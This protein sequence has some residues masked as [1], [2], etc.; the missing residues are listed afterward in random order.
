M[1]VFPVNIPPAPYAL[2]AIF[3]TILYTTV[4]LPKGNGSYNTHLSMDKLIDKSRIGP[5]T[6]DH[7]FA[8]S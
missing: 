6:P 8:P 7:R 1:A 5:F 2:I 4:I 3:I